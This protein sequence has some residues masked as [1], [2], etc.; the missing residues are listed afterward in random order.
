MMRLEERVRITVNRYATWSSLQ[1]TAANVASVNMPRYSRRVQSALEVFIDY[2]DNRS[3][4]E[5]FTFR[6]VLLS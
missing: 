1:A 4:I 3:R 2:L 5:M 6:L